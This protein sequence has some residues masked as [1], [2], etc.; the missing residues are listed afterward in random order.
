MVVILTGK[1]NNE[2]FKEIFEPRFYCPILVVYY[3][4]TDDILCDSISFDAN[5]LDEPLG[6][7]SKF[8]V[9]TLKSLQ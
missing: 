7:H 2:R 4:A 1:I 3:T 6:N 9:T 5:P 8:Q